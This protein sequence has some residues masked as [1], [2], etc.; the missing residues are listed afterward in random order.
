MNED[1]M[2]ELRDLQRLV[3]DPLP[4]DMLI[5]GARANLRSHIDAARLRDELHS[6]IE[7]P[8]PQDIVVPRWAAPATAKVGV[9]GWYRL[10][11]AAVAAVF[12]LVVS[13]TFAVSRPPPASALLD[14]AEA[15]ELLPDEMLGDVAV[16]RR[17]TIQSLTVVPVDAVDS[18]SGVVGAIVVVDEVRRI[19]TDGRIQIDTTTVDVEIVGPADQVA[20][21][22]IRVRIGVGTTRTVTTQRR[23]DPGVDPRLVTNDAADLAHRLNDIARSSGEPDAT[24]SAEILQEVAE[25]HTAYTLTP[26]QRA[27]VLVALDTVDGLDV[28]RPRDTLL[29]SASYTTERGRERLLLE[30]DARGWLVAETL[31]LFDG[32]PG[33]TTEPITGFHARY[34]EPEATP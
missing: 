6:L 28:Q 11:G 34:S 1:M 27:A 21:R 19:S 7:D 18:A 8:D 29:V 16:E 14:L 25:L 13:V 26:N 3:D 32:V 17:A 5:E 31:I 30:F 24:D 20:Q 23:D 15:V 9:H 2:T 4:E 12:V 22:E 33:V 10:A